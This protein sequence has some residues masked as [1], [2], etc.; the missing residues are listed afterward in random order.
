MGSWLM[1]KRH[2]EGELLKDHLVQKGAMHRD[3]E[4][5]TTRMEKIE[6]NTLNVQLRS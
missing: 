2:T 3:A 1:D 4:V 5:V 6:L